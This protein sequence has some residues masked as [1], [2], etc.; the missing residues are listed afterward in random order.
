MNKE[1]LIQLFREKPELLKDLDGDG[2]SIAVNDWWLK[3]GWPT[4][5]V[6]ELSVRHESDFSHPKSTIF[7]SQ[8]NPVPYMDGIGCLSFHYWIARTLELP[9]GDGDNE[10]R[11]Y[12]GRGSQA[13]EIAEKAEK[14]LASQG[15]VAPES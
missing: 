1:Q 2:H 5:V 13:A 14:F 3:R 7:D 8:G 11:E 15:I 6:N 12:L 4:E 10:I 9:W